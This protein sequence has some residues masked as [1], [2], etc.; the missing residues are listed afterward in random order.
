MKK[1]AGQLRLEL[2]QY[3]DVAA[4]AQ[5][6]SDLDEATRQQ[7]ERGRR[8]SEVLKQ[9]QY[10]PV[11]L[12]HQVAII[13][14]TTHGYVDRVPVERIEQFGAD[15][16]TYLETKGRAVVKAIDQTKELSEA[17]EAKLKQLLEDFVATFTS[18]A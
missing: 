8:T 11:P 6:G 18:G 5:F 14:A 10:Q 16:R 12:P 1:V 17:T 3:R 2:A 15:F 13:Y 4:F 7:L 9:G